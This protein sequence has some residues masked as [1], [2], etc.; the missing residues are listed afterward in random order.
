MF[1][2][3][4]WENILQIFTTSNLNNP[5]SLPLLDLVFV[6]LSKL[7]FKTTPEEQQI[8]QFSGKLIFLNET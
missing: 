8:H 2:T 6:Y 5:P 3:R 1:Y 4:G 7:Q